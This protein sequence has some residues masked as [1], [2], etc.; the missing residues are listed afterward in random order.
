M[1]LAQAAQVGAVVL[2]LVALAIPLA[3]PIAPALER[4]GRAGVPA[5]AAMA[6]V[7]AYSTVVATLLVWALSNWGWFVQAT[8]LRL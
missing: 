5:S 7:L 8:S 1:H 4:F 2:V 3:I 6:A